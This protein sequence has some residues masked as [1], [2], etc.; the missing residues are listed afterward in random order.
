[1]TAPLRTGMTPP[2]LASVGSWDNPLFADFGPSAV[3]SGD[4]EQA[5][6]LGPSAMGNALAARSDDAAGSTGE[7]R[8]R[9][10]RRSRA[11]Q[12]L[13][14]SKQREAFGGKPEQ[15]RA[16]DQAPGAERGDASEHRDEKNVGRKIEL[17]AAR[18]RRPDEVVGGRDEHADGQQ[19]AG[20]P[21]P[22][23]KR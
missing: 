11:T 18:Q 21:G 4:G 12:G 13:V 1:M 2:K 22:S 20:G 10:D 19:N 7:L 23:E 8:K 16:E 5:K 3:F 9:F 15:Q 6:N 14:L 17:A